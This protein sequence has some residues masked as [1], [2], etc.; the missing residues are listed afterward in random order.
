MNSKPRSNHATHGAIK[1]S[2]ATNCNPDIRK[3]NQ[4]IY[5][6]SLELQMSKKKLTFVICKTANS[7]NIFYS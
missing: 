1:P 4:L 5:R 3:K 7:I 2:K 6:N